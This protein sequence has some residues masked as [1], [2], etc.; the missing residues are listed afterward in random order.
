MALRKRRNVIFI[1]NNFYTQDRNQLDARFDLLEELYS[2]GIIKR[3]AALVTNDFFK[4]LRLLKRARDSGCT[5]L[6]GGIESFDNRVLKSYNKTYIT[7]IS[8][9]DVIQNCLDADIAFFYGLV[10]DPASRTVPEMESELNLVLEANNIPLPSFLSIAIPTLGTPMFYDALRH[11]KFLPNVLLRDLDATTIVLKPMDAMQ[12]VVK[13]VK[14]LQINERV[15]RAMA[16]NI[17]FFARHLH[18]PADVL[19]YMFVSSSMGE[20]KLSKFT[21]SPQSFRWWWNERSY[22]GGMEKLDRFYSPLIRVESQYEDYFIPTKLTNE[23]GNLVDDLKDDF[24][25][26]Q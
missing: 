11:E 5:A 2:Y 15:L 8:Q 13:F 19:L 7:S 21:K 12:T 16:H 20:S 6:F 4:D 24:P 22:I 3:W 18:L 23:K 9:F 10:L 1:D 25:K 17:S 26:I 14:G